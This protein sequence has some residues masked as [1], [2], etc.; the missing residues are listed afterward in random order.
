[1]YVALVSEHASPLAVLG[2]VDAGGQNVH[3][4]ALAAGLA[5][6]GHEVVVYTRRDD[7]DL[8]ERV[9]TRAGFEVVH[10][11][12]GPA[13][14]VAKDDLLPL[15]GTFGAG[16]GR[17]LERLRPDLVHAHFWMSGLAADA[18]A[19]PLGVPLVLTFHALGAVKRRHQGA[20]DTSPRRRLEIERR[21]A[22]TA[23]QVIAT[24]SD[25]V[26]ELRRLGM[27]AD[28]VR[29]VPCGVDVELFTPDSGIALPDSPPA[30]AGPGRRHPY[31]LVS[32]GRMVPRKGFADLLHA[33]ARLPDTELVIVGGQSGD[34]AGQA[35]YERLR[36]IAHQLGVSDRVHFAGTVARPAM[37]ALLRSADLVVC[38]PWYEPF[39]ITP[40]ES[41]ACGV[42]VVGTAVGGLL[43]SVAE[44]ATGTLVAPRDPVALADAIAAL[45]ADPAR[46]QA[47]GRAGR[48]RAVARYSWARV[49]EATLA[50]Y[51]E[52]L[53]GAAG[54]SSLT[55]RAGTR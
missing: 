31:R 45:L 17:D 6:A 27:P 10:L 2:G 30:L 18:V 50:G 3:V 29:V 15:M 14:Y 26:V 38:P 28:R 12:A 52:V 32:V 16:L 54:R 7:P 9:A 34:L 8:P 41:M 42:P 53:A 11:T 40:L 36:S 24:C 37:P 23:D 5:D 48:E 21:L 25:E 43:D 13:A 4:A 19:R 44:G 33:L 39:G 51:A 47:Y 46:R 22:A 1:M 49:T 55:T 20:A 35:E